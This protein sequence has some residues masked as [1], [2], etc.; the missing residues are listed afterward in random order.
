MK[1]SI[2][3]SFIFIGAYALSAI[4]GWEPMA[5]LFFSLSPLVVI[6]VVYRVLRDPQEVKV[7]F[8]D[9]FYQDE[10]HPRVK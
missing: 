6:W 10:S 2:L 5:M 9:H 1:N 4:I 3:F 8:E 7:T